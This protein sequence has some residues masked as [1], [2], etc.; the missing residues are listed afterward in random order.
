MY[1]NEKEKTIIYCEQK[2][3]IN[4]DTEKSVETK[5]KVKLMREQ[6]KR[7]YPDYTIECYIFAAR[8]LS[9]DETVAK[10]IIKRKYKDIDVIGVND[11]LKLFNITPIKDYN[12]YKKI[13]HDI[14]V[15]KFN[16]SSS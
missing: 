9:K 10:D 13:I 3:N 6:I 11:F 7:N 1:I 12:M 5:K 2:N 8:Y 4:L 15:R 16:I 14:C